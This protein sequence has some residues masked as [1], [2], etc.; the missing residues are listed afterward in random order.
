MTLETK[1]APNTTVGQRRSPMGQLSALVSVKTRRFAPTP[2]G[3][4][5]LTPTVRAL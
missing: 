5:V 4:R 2:S 3:A 1:D